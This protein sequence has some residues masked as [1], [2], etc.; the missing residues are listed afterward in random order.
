LPNYN[1]TNFARPGYGT[2]QVLDQ[3]ENA[4]KEYEKPKKIILCYSYFHE[5]RNLLS[6]SYQYKLHQ[7]FE[8]LQLDMDK[9][10]YP[11]CKLTDEGFVKSYLNITESFYPLPFRESSALINISEKALVKFKSRRNS[12]LEASQV[13]I[14][15]INDLCLSNEI[16]LVVA[17][18][19]LAPNSNLIHDFCLNS[20]IEYINI[21]PDFHKGGFRNLPYD[22]HP[23]KAAHEVYAS[24]L[25]E[26]L[27][28]TSY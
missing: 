22:M 4:L 27:S 16:R 21:S 12:K 7:G 23:N 8:M 28:Q 18:I 14:G 9:M 20:G 2:L 13:L 26:Y 3:L 19:E 1:L 15:Q 11:M 10:I 6:A 5:E 17:D 24:K 25:I